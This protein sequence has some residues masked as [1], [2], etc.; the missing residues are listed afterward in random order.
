LTDETDWT[1]LEELVQGIRLGKLKS[2]AGRPPHLRALCG[3]MMLRATRDATWRELEDLIK[4]YA[5]ARYLCGLTET[6]WSPDHRTLHDFAVLLGEEG[7]RLFNEYS[8]RWAVT[9]KLADPSVMVADTT[10]QEA[11]IP[12]PNE[13][14]LMATFLASMANAADKA[15]SALKAF[16]TKAKSKLKEAKE[17]VRAYRLF[18]KTK[19][20]KD[21]AVAEMAALVEG[22]Q[23]QLARTLEA[24]R[25]TPARLAKHAKIAHSKVEQLHGTM[26]RLLPQIRYWL[27]T[28]F[29]ASGKVVSVHV[30]ELYSVVRGKVGKTVEFGLSWGVSRLRGGFVLLR[31]AQERL[32]LQD[33]RF[34]VLAVRD[35]AS[36]FGSVPLAYAYD[37][38]GYSAKNV[39][40]L[41]DLGVRDVGLAPT[42]K[43]GWSVSGSKREEL[44]KERALVEGV[45]GVIKSRR[46]G[47]NRPRARSVRMMGTYGQMAALGFNL[48][49][50]VRCFAKRRKVVV[51][52]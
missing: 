44:V 47:F 3:A 50:L 38:G 19:E 42:G 40:E 5:P 46:Y 52:G 14:G 34:A 20:A 48:N 33:K 45:I 22:V 17:K 13:M 6:D 36:L 23:E 9:E 39:T 49:K 21:K 31:M 43:T 7:V 8:V 32:E 28:G 25:S 26:S 11:A 15:G 37:R 2:A 35:H 10:A 27:R 4:H 41:K 18:A 12:Y 16:V 29:V 24:A 51:V 1:E 30:P